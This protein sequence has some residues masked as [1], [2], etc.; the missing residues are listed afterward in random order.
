MVAVAAQLDGVYGPQSTTGGSLALSTC[1]DS[2]GPFAWLF[3]ST[4]TITTDPVTVSPDICANEPW[5]Q[6]SQYTLTKTCG[7][8]EITM[9]ANL[10]SDGTSLSMMVVV[11]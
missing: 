1:E 6:P 7:G 8:A 5:L 2:S 3:N 11:S 4:L 10:S 9:N